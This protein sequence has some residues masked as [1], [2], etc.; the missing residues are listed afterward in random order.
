MA[1]QPADAQELPE[2]LLST[3]AKFGDNIARVL[4]SLGLAYIQ[5]G[6]QNNLRPLGGY[7]NLLDLGRADDGSDAGLNSYGTVSDYVSHWV[8]TGDLPKRVKP[9]QRIMT[10][11]LPH[12]VSGVTGTASSLQRREALRGELVKLKGEYEKELMSYSDQLDQSTNVL[13]SPPLW[14]S[15]KDLI[16]SALDQLVDAIG[17]IDV[18]DDDFGDKENKYEGDFPA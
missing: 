2:K 11:L 13:S 3:S 18:K 12:R 4:E 1:S 9:D 7:V 6:V 5:V 10:Q 15:M 17:L 16:Y 8:H 14:V